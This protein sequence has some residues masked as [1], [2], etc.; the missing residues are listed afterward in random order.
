MSGDDVGGSTES[1]SSPTAR[2]AASPTSRRSGR[3]WRVGA[4]A[5]AIGI[6]AGVGVVWLR[7][8]AD[9]AEGMTWD[10]V[11]AQPDWVARDLD[12]GG[13]RWA[14][15]S[16][17]IGRSTYWECFNGPPAEH[18]S[19]LASDRSYRGQVRVVHVESPGRPSARDRIEFA[20]EGRVVP[21]SAFSPNACG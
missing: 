19:P 21:F 8:P 1:A 17:S 10:D 15:H 20:T 7:P 5:L 13:G 12:F 2:K 14:I 6:A 9:L 11:V 4:G 16:I 18:R 3:W